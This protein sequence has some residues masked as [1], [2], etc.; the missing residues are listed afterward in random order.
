MDKGDSTNPIKNDD[1]QR[2]KNANFTN[3]YE[4][5]KMPIETNAP[6]IVNQVEVNSDQGNS[7]TN[8]FRNSPRKLNTNAAKK[9]SNLKKN[10][11]TIMNLVCLTTF[12]IVVF[13]QLNIYLENQINTV[14]KDENTFNTTSNSLVF[15]NK[16]QINDFNTKLYFKASRNKFILAEKYLIISP[17]RTTQRRYKQKTSKHNKY[18]IPVELLK[19]INQYQNLYINPF[20]AKLDYEETSV[21]ENKYVY[22]TTSTF[23]KL[24]G[25]QIKLLKADIN[26]LNNTN[27]TD[28]NYEE[29]LNPLYSTNN[30]LMEKLKDFSSE[31]N[32]NFYQTQS[33]TAAI[34]YDYVL[35]NY[36]ANY[37]IPVFILYTINP[38]GS[39]KQEIILNYLRVSLYTSDTDIFRLVCE[40]LYIIS[41]MSYIYFFIVK[42]ISTTQE[43]YQAHCQELKSK[44]RDLLTKDEIK[45]DR[46]NKINNMRQINSKIST[47]KQKNVLARSKKKKG[48]TVSTFLHSKTLSY[49]SKENHNAFLK[50]IEEKLEIEVKDKAQSKKLLFFKTCIMKFPS[51]ICSIIFSVLC[52]I[53]WLVYISNHF[54]FWKSITSN[55]SIDDP[56]IYHPYILKKMNNPLTDNQIYELYNMSNILKT[57][58][59][60]VCLNLLFIFS[61]LLIIFKNLVK[62]AE[63]FIE[64]FSLAFV[65]IISY[66]I[67][68]I[69]LVLSFSLLIL[70][71]YSS[72]PELSTLS[73]TF[74]QVFSFS[75]ISFD[76]IYIKMYKHDSLMTIIILLTIIILMRFI[77]LKMI[78]AIL[79]Y[80]F[81]FS[82]N[83]YEA[84]NSESNFK[85]K[86]F[87]DLL[88]LPSDLTYNLAKK[89][90]KIASKAL[91]SIIYCCDKTSKKKP[92]D[93]L[94]RH[95]SLY[96]KS[97]NIL[98]DNIHRRTRFNSVNFLSTKENTNIL[99]P[100][101]VNY[102]EMTRKQEELLFS[103][104][105]ENMYSN[106]NKLEQEGI[107][108]NIS[109]EEVI[110]NEEEMI[111]IVDE[112]S[113]DKEE[114]Q[115]PNKHKE[116]IV[117]NMEEDKNLMEE[118]LPED[119]KDCKVQLSDDYSHVVRNVY[120][121]SDK[122]IYLI[123]SHNE[124]Y[125]KNKSLKLIF[126]SLFIICSVVT[127]FFSSITPYKNFF[128]TAFIR[129]FSNHPS[130]INKR[131]FNIKNTQQ[132]ND[133]IFNVLPKFYQYDNDRKEFTI[134]N[135]NVLLKDTIVL[136]VKRNNYNNTLPFELGCRMIGNFDSKYNHKENRTSYNLNAT[137]TVIYS[138]NKSYYQEGA[139]VYNLNMYDYFKNYD[140]YNSLKK[141]STIKTNHPYFHYLTQKER[142]LLIDPL[143]TNVY[144][145]SLIM[146]YEYNILV[147]TTFIFNIKEGSLVDKSLQTKIV[148]TE[149]SVKFAVVSYIFDIV[150]IILIC[151]FLFDYFVKIRNMNS[152]Y[153]R[154]QYD[155]IRTLSYSAQELRRH[156]NHEILRKLLYILNFFFFVDTIIIITGLGYIVSRIIYIVDHQKFLNALELNYHSLTIEE[157]RNLI[158]YESQIKDSFLYF[159]SVLINAMSIR[160]LF[161]I[162]FG[163]FFGI[164]IKT[165]QT[166]ADLMSIFVT[167]LLLTQPAFVCYC[168][169]AFG[170]NVST[171]STWI[172]SFL[173]TLIT[174]FGTFD[175][176][177]FN[178]THE[179][180]GP[181]FYYLYL[182]IINLILINLF[183]ATLDRAY[184]SVKDKIK[185]IAEEFDFKYA[186]CFCCYKRKSLYHYTEHQLN[187]EYDKNR[188]KD[189]P[190]VQLTLHTQYER[191]AFSEIETIK[192]ITLENGIIAEL[193]KWKLIE[194]AYL[195]LKIGGKLKSFENNQ[196]KDMQPKHRLTSGVFM[197]LFLNDIIGNFERNILTIERYYLH[198]MKFKEYQNY[199]KK[200]TKI[201]YENNHILK[202]IE[203]VE[204]E[205]FNQLKEFEKYQV[206]NNKINDLNNIDDDEEYKYNKTSEDN[207]TDN[208]NISSEL[209]RDKKEESDQDESQNSESYD[210]DVLSNYSL[211]DE[212]I[213]INKSRLDNEE[214]SS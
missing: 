2:Q 72:I 78:L 109:N 99:I 107:I 68:F 60:L 77:V 32:S 133:F 5:G 179:N 27:L 69:T 190:E 65:D 145:E 149:N 82:A 34:I 183:V 10:I 35:L 24:G 132:I 164:I 91:D 163:R 75:I 21:L 42:L 40:I 150:F 38:T 29:A 212:E 56:D 108:V 18:I 140:L 41:F 206:I 188:F 44:L 17:L 100:T 22:E 181:L 64:C 160:L 131:F 112:V 52:T 84:I 89:F 134:L 111:K 202:E 159:S 138:Y 154:W 113:P 136:S 173:Y 214:S 67:I 50:H 126:Y 152:L 200:F 101:K 208:D 81:N 70:F 49:I 122:D 4:K 178:N 195:S 3:S 20:E 168:Y 13:L 45:N 19:T 120:F 121:D 106:Q 55:E 153:E 1:N 96:K 114:L 23:M 162:D 166:S 105:N 9:P 139:Y 210:N 83:K 127:I 95:I 204:I 80:W 161:I 142:S 54:S 26:S 63:I 43:D 28:V 186:F 192:L 46:L 92:G 79:I 16:S 201:Q 30:N 88:K 180:L 146:N 115:S 12:I 47:S 203:T 171:Y 177:G 86:E 211:D 97:G 85:N 172:S 119:I 157:I 135:N 147:S 7:N 151:L 141:D 62:K 176:D 207:V 102:Q 123:K 11:E 169:I 90:I 118:Q 158:D 197:I 71:F 205:F 76:D 129:L 94:N 170:F 209:I 124:K 93:I 61:R 116:N 15:Y 6:L 189:P 39:F 53:Y 199:F 175:P 144:A 148:K 185:T 73:G 125:Y 143:V 36:E 59:T 51:T 33:K 194:A 193:I 128:S 14:I 31:F 37:I 110:N 137:N 98:R 48:K 167:M 104:E 191:Q 184:R 182:I 165:I 57:Y 174:L 187:C 25:Y 130:N 74:Q 117:Q 87:L 156:F 66:L 196:Y 155:Q 103:N 8:S 58:R 198:Q 213:K